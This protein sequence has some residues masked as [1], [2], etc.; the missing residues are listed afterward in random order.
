MAPAPAPAPVAAVLRNNRSLGTTALAVNKYG[1]YA[2]PTSSSPSP[3]VDPLPPSSSLPL[4]P[5]AIHDKR[6]RVVV[7]E[8]APQPLEALPRIILPPP[9]IPDDAP[10][11]PSSRSPLSPLLMRMNSKR[12]TLMERIEGWWD[13][14]LVDMKQTM[15]ARSASRRNVQKV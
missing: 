4:A 7:Q 8:V 9:R 13:L 2:P 6:R 1:F 5:T 14:G 12:R 3:D 11:S 10:Q 15:L